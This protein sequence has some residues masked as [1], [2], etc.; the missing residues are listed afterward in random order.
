M[1]PTRLKTE[2]H[3]LDLGYNT[4]HTFELT[5]MDND[6]YDMLQA[7]NMLAVKQ[8]HRWGRVSVS[9]VIIHGGSE[10]FS[11]TRTYS[12]GVI[13]FYLEGNTLLKS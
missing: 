13:H 5:I 9:S 11:S 6:T 8:N 1:K 10:L 2:K 7:L 12:P 3:Y 4:Y